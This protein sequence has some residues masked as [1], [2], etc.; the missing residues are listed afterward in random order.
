M[1]RWMKCVERL[2]PS[3]LSSI[4]YFNNWRALGC[5]QRHPPVR[6]IVTAYIGLSSLW[7]NTFGF[8]VE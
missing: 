1:K 2:S 7:P 6:R 5:Q 3:L 8:V 4:T